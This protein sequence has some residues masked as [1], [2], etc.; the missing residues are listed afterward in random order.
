MKLAIEI[1]NKEIEKREILLITEKNVLVMN[2]MYSSIVDLK[3][4]VEHLSNPID[5]HELLAN[6]HRHNTVDENEALNS[7]I[8]K[9]VD[10]Y[11]KNHLKTE[12]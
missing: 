7:F 3:N 8:D 4:T 11:L 1:L 2:D 12:S 10:D 6:Y 5:E 9:H